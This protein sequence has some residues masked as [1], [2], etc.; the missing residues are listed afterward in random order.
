M[1]S[2]PATTSAAAAPA[3]S[4]PAGNRHWLILAV[5]VCAQMLVWLDN[6]VLNLAVKTLA[7]PARGL[8][9]T[10][11][12]LQWSI[13]AFT[14]V[15]A[16]LLFTG[17]VL[18]DRFGH[19]RVLAI[20]LSIFGAASV[21]AAYAGS[22]DQLIAARAVMGAGG[23]TLMPATLSIIVFAIPPALRMRAIAIWSAS[24]GVGIATGPLVSGVLL[25]HFWWGSV[26]L[27]NVPI[28]LAGLLGIALVVPS[29]HNPMRRR[30]DFP[31]VA[32]SIAGLV[33]LVFGIIRGGDKP[34]GDA[35]VWV[36]VLAGVLVLGLFGLIELR[37]PEPG[38]D[39][40]LFKER[41]FAGG[42]LAMLFVFFGLAGQVF[43]STFYLQGVRSVR[44]TDVGLMLLAPAFGLVLGTQVSPRLV[45]S[46]TARWVIV[47]GMVAAIAT[48]G[49][50]VFFGLHTP[51]AWYE[52][53][54]LVQGFGMGL[55]TAP[56]T[57][58][59]MASLPRERSGAG[60]A[61]ATSMRQIGATL[62]VAV[63]G[64]MIAAAY[65]HR[66][67]G[68]LAD[69]PDAARQQAS[70][71]AEATRF[72]AGPLGRP[73]LV[74][75]ANNAYLHGMYVASFWATVIS[76]LG[77][78]MILYFFRAPRPAP[79]AAPAATPAA[80]PAATSPQPAAQ[81]ADPTAAR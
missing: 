49:A 1:T 39:L 56:T 64:S 36:P 41:R 5:L 81:P 4:N 79:P 74:T 60:S 40:R 42:S 52:L 20:G 48:F 22:P 9:A 7:D 37:V 51:L 76:L 27:I 70:V 61:V 72:V 10:P 66:I 78:A 17:G 21:W 14:L 16:A 59:I 33:L 54:L 45:A 50:H 43:Y 75:D 38:M 28:V 24:S 19:R 29:T 34:W 6:S 15:F 47:G 2:Q 69:L 73:D 11:G 46:F 63:L 44:P 65:R 58:A 3:P 30:F 32:L 35:T 71:S 13:G 23:A 18:G 77:A 80:A 25:D 57:S 53:L 67:A 68:V 62:G 26:F 12:E 31:G 55:V 8:A